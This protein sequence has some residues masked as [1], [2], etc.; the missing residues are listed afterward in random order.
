MCRGGVS[1]KPVEKGDETISPK[2]MHGFVMV[3]SSGVR[4][5]SFFPHRLEFEY[6]VGLGLKDS[7]V[8]QL[9][10]GLFAAPRQRS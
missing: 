9:S 5:V 6:L 7:E 4:A 1:N 2:R 10:S 8:R 3:V